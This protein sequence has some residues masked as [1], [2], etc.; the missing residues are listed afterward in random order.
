ML[1]TRRTL[2][3][4]ILGSIAILPLLV[5]P[6]MVGG[7]VDYL[8]MS[9]RLAGWA[10]AA[11]FLGSG[12]AAV[13][14][15]LRIHHLDLRRLAW[16]GLWIML[17]CDLAC[18][19]AVSLP[20]W[21]YF[22]L[23]LIAGIGSAGVYAG[24]MS[25]FARSREPDR[26]YGLFMAIQFA[27]SAIGLYGIP[28]LLPV[29]GIEGLHIGFVAA[30]LVALSLVAKLPDRNERQAHA[31][32]VT[33]E[34]RILATR[35]SIVCLL[36]IW[37]FEAANMS[38]FTYA[39]RIGLAASLDYGQIGVIL[40]IAT[41]LGIPSALAVVWLGNRWGHFLPILLGAGCQFLALIL[42]VLAPSPTVYI[43]AMC[44]LAS[45]WAF[46]LPYFQAIE[47][48]IDPGGS[49]V[50]AGGC[51]TALGGFA[52][53]ATAAMLVQPGSYSTMLMAA[54][55]AYLFVIVLMRY[56][57]ARISKKGSG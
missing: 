17:A 33:I 1:N 27:G 23:R 43:A 51:A 15:S 24:V 49:V 53:P 26:A 30:D 25:A 47:A 5:L 21:L 41:I 54:A 11:W 12:G 13:L 8:D 38:H 4:S 44:M 29:A 46:S 42:L 3:I 22:A 9:E 7:L 10:A 57:V 32:P 55:G 36:G 20:T 14:I 18:V 28:F 40:G 34:W 50:V 6:V 37:L 2:S 39:E 31:V 45:A 56:V 16:S 48:D 35:T 52:G 19:A